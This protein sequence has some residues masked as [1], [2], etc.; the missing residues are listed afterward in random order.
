MFFVLTGYIRRLSGWFWCFIRTSKNCVLGFD[1]HCII[2]LSHDFLS[3][4]VI[5]YILPMKLCL[6]SHQWIFSQ[7]YHSGSVNMELCTTSFYARGFMV[8]IIPKNVYMTHILNIPVINFFYWVSWDS[9]LKIVKIFLH[10][11]HN[12]TNTLLA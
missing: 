7:W 5:P 8:I 1:D 3:G 4:G 9:F 6:H 12:S 10:N 11:I 2:S